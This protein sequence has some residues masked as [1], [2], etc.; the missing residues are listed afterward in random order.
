MTIAGA[1]AHFYYARGNID[2]MPASPVWSSFKVTLIYHMGTV[3]IGSFLVA[4]LIFVRIVLEF[5]HRRLKYLGGS[6]YTSWVRYI[7]GCV[8]CFLWILEKIVK[9][10]NRYVSNQRERVY[11]IA[12]ASHK[13]L[14]SSTQ[15]I[16]S[17]ALANMYMIC[18][19]GS[20]AYRWSPYI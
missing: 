18:I 7:M 9:F 5:L 13:S 10:I 8:S 3:A 4:L 1:I 6:K 20:I 14:H 15:V 11:R 16:Q 19:Y 12:P 2:R 17:M